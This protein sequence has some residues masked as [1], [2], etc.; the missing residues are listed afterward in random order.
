M[1]DQ[2]TLSTLP[3]EAVPSFRFRKRFFRRYSWAALTK[4][5][6]GKK[7]EVTLAS[8]E[9]FMLRVGDQLSEII[10]QQGCHEPDLTS[11]LLPFIKP[12]MTVFDI[13]ANIG[14]FT[15]LMARR[16]GASGSV[17][18]F[19]INPNVLDLLEENIRIARVDNVR[20]ARLAAA[21]NN[22]ESE[23]FVPRA[24]D[25]GE[26]S[27]KSSNRYEAEGTIKVR[28]VALDDYIRENA[29]G[30]V[31]LVKIDIEGGESEAFEGARQLLSSPQRPVLMFEAL[32]TACNNFGVTW[33][34]V[35]EKVKGFGYRVHQGDSANFFATPLT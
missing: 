12:G 32:D 1:T 34:D 30:R 17:H 26:G 7:I 18:A 22:G 27:L 16:V 25:E 13:G 28:T 9:P 8:G 4:M 11:K 24:G 23:F 31:D 2:R 29:I 15:V 35:V 33:L 5:R 19:E 21:R 14:F 3:F 10:Y 6:A 20:I